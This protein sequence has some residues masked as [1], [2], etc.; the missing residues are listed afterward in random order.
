[1]R[2]KLFLNIQTNKPVSSNPFLAATGIEV[3]LI[4][5]AMY[6]CSNP[7]LVAAV[8]QAGGIGIIQPMSLT[9]V[10]GLDLRQGIRRIRS[11]TDKPVG[12]NLLIERSSQKYQRRIREWYEIAL[13]EGIRFYITALGDPAWVVERAAQHDCVIYHDVVNQRHAQKALDAGVDGFI[14][15]NNRAGG[16]AGANTPEQLIEQIGPLGKPLICAG[17]IGDSADFAQ[18]LALGYQGVQLGT[19]FI[20]SEE[21]S[22]HQ[23][24]KD[25]IMSADAEDIVLT[26]KISGVPVSVINTPSVQKMGTHAG[27]IARW[28]LRGR[29][30]RHW[31]RMFYSLRSIFSLKKAT[32]QG[33]SYKDFFQAGKSVDKIFQVESAADIV[34]GFARVYRSHQPVKPAE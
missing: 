15:V 2:D 11:L 17:G 28:M 19:R 6:P 27:G 29:K 31:M 13:E 32:L 26:E 8:S 7:E 20:C 21:C 18:M 33:L 23:D 14:C 25:A 30:T 3:P 24:Y 12:M 34:A 10:F 22:A 1:M 9:Y 5:G 16:H 4:C